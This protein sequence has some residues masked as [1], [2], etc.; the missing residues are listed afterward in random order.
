MGGCEQPRQSTLYSMSG[1][2]KHGGL[3]LYWVR[4][5]ARFLCCGPRGRG[6]T[7]GLGWRG[8]WAGSGG[9]LVGLMNDGS[10]EAHSHSMDILSTQTPDPNDED[11][12][13]D[14]S[15]TVFFSEGDIR[16]TQSI[17]VRVPQ[18]NNLTAPALT[19]PLMSEENNTE[20]NAG[21]SHPR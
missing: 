19:V 20:E 14:D 4:L 16:S 18:G 5:S 21:P 10:E 8:R 2:Q 13:E 3:R 11:E 9:G 1:Q 6:A 17:E 12:D 7:N 15:E